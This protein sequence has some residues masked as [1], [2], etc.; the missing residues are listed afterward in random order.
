MA[1]VFTEA[2]F[3]FILFII[4]FLSLLHN[5]NVQL[6][7]NRLQRYKKI[8]SWRFYLWLKKLPYIVQN[9]KYVSFCIKKRYLCAV[10]EK[11]VK[12]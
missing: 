6:C 7:P 10:N 2:I 1:S 11:F 12:K 4:L 8:R 3:L 5:Y 9:G